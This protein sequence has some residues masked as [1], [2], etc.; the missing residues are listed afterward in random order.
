MKTL[1][2]EPILSDEEVK[3]FALNEQR[4]LT[5]DDKEECDDLKSKIENLNKMLPN[6]FQS[7]IEKWENYV[8][9]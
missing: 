3:V 7:C 4:Y 6:D 2:V 9:N 1:T 5:E 8:A